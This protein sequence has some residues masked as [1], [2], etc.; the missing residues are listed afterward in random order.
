MQ[1]L[2]NANFGLTW[3]YAD[4]LQQVDFGG[5]GIAYYVYDSNGHAYKKS[6][7]KWKYY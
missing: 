4:Q 5:G 1:N 7:R 3:N 6:N 2:Q